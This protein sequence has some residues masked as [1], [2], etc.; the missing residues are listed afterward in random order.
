MRPEAHAASW[1]AAGTPHSAGSTVAG[2]PPS[3]P[4]PLKSWP[5]ALPTWIVSIC[6]R[7]DL[8]RGQ[9]ARDRVGH[10]VAHLEALLGVVAGVVGLVTAEDEDVGAHRGLPPVGSADRGRGCEVASG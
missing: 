8:R 10:E 9:R 6:G 7:V 4:C 2:M 1:R 5:K 3:W